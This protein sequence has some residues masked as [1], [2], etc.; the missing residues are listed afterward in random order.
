V[1]NPPNPWQ[2]AHVEWLGEPPPALPE[3]HEEQASSILSRNDSPDLPFRWSLNP[4][5]GCHHGCA[6]CYARTTHEYLGWGAGTDFEKRL[7]V[8]SN[9]AQL[10]AAAFARKS[11]VGERIAFSGG[12][13]CYQPLEA[14]YG[15]T[16]ACL[17]VCLEHRNP[18][19]VLTKGALVRR[20]AEL[21]G[22]LA[23]E[24]RATVQISI[25]FADQPSAGALEPGASSV[26]ARFD[27]IRVLAEQG[28]P[29]GLAIAPL[30][31]G[32]NDSQ[33]PELLE[34]AAAAGAGSAWTILLR[35]PG[36]VRPVFEQRLQEA[37]PGRA[38]AVMSAL[39]EMGDGRVS[40]AGF[41]Q[42]MVGSGPRWQA[43]EDLFALHCR[44]LGLSPG[45]RAP[46]DGPTTFRRPGD[47]QGELFAP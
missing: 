40:R 46:N 8:K 29:V 45:E 42:R 20:D 6:Y 7:V 4:Y 2:G 39:R 9:A 33:V 34:R 16:R 1:S 35:L 3:L 22:A 38:R 25:P 23:R 13:D 43:L 24:A 30:I 21:L 17:A 27:A 31:P 32:L 19:V 44:R 15:L 10:L 14:D 5:R 47:G 36:S 26:A 11:W 18:V 12:T 28:V 37:L 41:G